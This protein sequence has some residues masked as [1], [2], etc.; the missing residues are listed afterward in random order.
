MT[1]LPQNRQLFTVAE[2][3]T[4]LGFSY[5]HLLRLVMRGQIPAVRVLSSW[6]IRRKTLLRLLQGV[7]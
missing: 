6:R 2:V 7:R 4:I 3:A 5:R 1:P